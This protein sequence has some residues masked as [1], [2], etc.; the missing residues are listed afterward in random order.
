MK[1]KMCMYVYLHHTCTKKLNVL[2]KNVNKHLS[3][4]IHCM[5]DLTHIGTLKMINLCNHPFLITF[6]VME[7]ETLLIKHGPETDTLS[8]ISTELNSVI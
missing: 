3:D 8:K 6:K 4:T 5:K 2:T 1:L 7:T